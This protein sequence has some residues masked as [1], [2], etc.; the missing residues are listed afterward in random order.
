MVLDDFKRFVCNE[1]D[2]ERKM[3]YVKENFDEKAY[4]FWFLEYDKLE[5]QCEVDYITKNE[6]TGFL[7][8]CEFFKKWV[9][10]V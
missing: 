4:S 2:N 8:R 5:G 9:Y 7:D 3:N 10:A 6:C 1:K